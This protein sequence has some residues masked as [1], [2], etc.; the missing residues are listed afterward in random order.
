MELS[1]KTKIFFILFLFLAI[2]ISS[3]FLL[4]LFFPKKETNRNY[5]IL[6]GPNQWSNLPLLTIKSTSSNEQNHKSIELEIQKLFYLLKKIGFPTRFYGKRILRKEDEMQENEKYIHYINYERENESVLW[7]ALEMVQKN[8]KN[9]INHEEMVR[10]MEMYSEMK[11]GISTSCIVKHA[12]QYKLPISRMNQDNFVL[13]SFGIHQKR[14][15]STVTSLTSQISVDITQNKQLT[16]FLLSKVGIPV[17]WGKIVENKEDAWNTYQ[18]RGLDV[19]L[20]P[21]EGHQGKGVSILPRTKIEI[22]NAYSLAA[23]IYSNDNGNGN[24]ENSRRSKK[25]LMEEYIEGQDYRVLVVNNNVVA[26]A[27]RFPP[28]IRGDGQSSIDQLIDQLNLD[29]R[30]QTKHNGFL[31]KIVKDEYLSEELKKQGFSSVSH[32]PN[33]NQVLFLRRQANL[34]TGGT[35]RNIDLGAIHDLNLYFF[36]L[37]SKIM[38]LDI[39][40]IDVVSQDLSVPLTTQ[41]AIIEVNTGP[42][43]RM[44]FLQKKENENKIGSSIFQYLFPNPEK[45]I[46]IIAITGTNGKTTTTFLVSHILQHVYSIVGSVTTHGIC[47]NNQVIRS[48]DCSGPQSARA[49]LHHPRVDAVVLE[50]A[51]GGIIREGLGYDQSTVGVILNIG[52]GDHLGMDDILTTEDIFRVKSTVMKA[53]A[54]NGFAVINANDTILRNNIPWILST[55]QIIW[56]SIDP[57]TIPQHASKFVIYDE[58]RLKIIEN[59]LVLFEIK[60]TDIPCTHQGT[61]LF[62]IE[63]VLASMAVAWS[64]QISFSILRHSLETFVPPLGRGNLLVYPLANVLVDYAHNI[65]ALENIISSFHSLPPS[66]SSIIMFGAP[67]DRRDKDILLLTQK[68]NE[69]CK[70]LILFEDD[71]LR[72]GRKKGE[73]LQLMKQNVD[74]KEGENVHLFHSE[75]EAVLFVLFFLKTQKEKNLS[76]NV[77]FLLDNVE[78]Y[79]PKI[80]Q[81]LNNI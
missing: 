22:E 36:R 14:I 21:L 46:P 73:L 42:G 51:R 44:H 10:L 27:Q 63:N 65:D 19:V 11:L 39:A 54:Q 2:L 52:Q 18:A 32:I 66:S 8:Q 1:R 45:K 31:T 72:R 53:I 79:H 70:V 43:L 48:C 74:K 30:R 56:F 55:P 17:P 64:M 29:P 13:I 26:V 67:G 60:T 6:R 12:K 78:K 16:K 9:E 34:S 80:T 62:Q 71:G 35:A 81:F 41:G 47:F 58:Q 77:L 5:K 50:V 24:D 4:V 57:L 38:G 75:E 25:V 20:K 49:V 76:S 59:H 7:K 33:K 69:N 15:M 68:V 28:T 61:F 40:G 37:A 23:K 3:F